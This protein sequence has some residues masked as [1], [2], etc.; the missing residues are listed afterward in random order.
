PRTV[1]THQVRWAGWADA[2]GLAAQHGAAMGFDDYQWG[3]WLVTAAGAPALG[4]LSGSGQ[5]MRYVGA[6]RPI[7]PIYQQHTLLVDEEL[8]PDAGDRH[9]SLGAAVAAARQVIDASIGGDYTPIT[10]Q[11]HVDYFYPSNSDWA[12]QTTQYALQH[13]ALALNAQT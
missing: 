5:P 13:G 2:A 3:P 7:L 11:Y 1:R 8:A 9:L 12:L 10:T 6:S 4:Y